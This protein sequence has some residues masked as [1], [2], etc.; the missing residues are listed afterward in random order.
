MPRASSVPPR[1]L[2]PDAH[3]ALRRSHFSG[4]KEIQFPILGSGST[5]LKLFHFSLGPKTSLFRR[6]ECVFRLGRV[7]LRPF[8]A[9]PTHCS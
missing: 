6:V 9:H 8:I 7:L 4:N 5:Q 3:W 1:I 2:R